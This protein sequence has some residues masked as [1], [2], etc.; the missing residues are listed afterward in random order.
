VAVETAATLH[1]SLSG[2]LGTVLFFVNKIAGL[3]ETEML[4]NK[5]IV[6]SFA[7]LCMNH[8]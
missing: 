4:A 3:H 5:R 8:P 7:H 1:N 2:T 6:P